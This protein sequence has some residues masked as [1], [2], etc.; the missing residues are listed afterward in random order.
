MRLGAV[1]RH[2]LRERLAALL[3]QALSAEGGQAEAL[4]AYEQTRSRLAD[5]LGSDP[6]AELTSPPRELL[7]SDPTPAQVRPTAQ[8]TS[9]VGRSGEAGEVAGRAAG[10]GP[11]GD[12][13]GP[14]RGGQDP[15]VRGGGEGHR[16]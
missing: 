15:A 12:A 14:G 6:S 1:T 10:G 8:L 9:F 5:E 11:A 3:I 16:R 7:E 4:A 13:G 2:P